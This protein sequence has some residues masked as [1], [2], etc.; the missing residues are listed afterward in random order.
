LTSLFIAPKVMLH[1]QISIAVRKRTLTF[2]TGSEPGQ[3]CYCTCTAR[4]F[5]GQTLHSSQNLCS[6][7]RYYYAIYGVWKSTATEQNWQFK[8]ITSENQTSW[9]FEQS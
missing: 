3:V 7:S 1:L 4:T 8:I 5:M 2:Q 6:N 9:V